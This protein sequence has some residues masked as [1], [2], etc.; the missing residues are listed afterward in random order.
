M[1]RLTPF[2]PHQ[3]YAMYSSGAKKTSPLAVMETIWAIRRTRE[4]KTFSIHGIAR[5][6]NIS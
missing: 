4:E 6:Y 5:T 3:Y 2:A 1:F